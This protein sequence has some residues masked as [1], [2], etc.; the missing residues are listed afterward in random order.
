MQKWQ[1]PSTWEFQ[2]IGFGRW[3]E[4]QDSIPG[5]LIYDRWFFILVWVGILFPL[6]SPTWAQEYSELWGATGEKWSPTS[7]LPDFS[8]AGYH[9][10]EKPIPTI[11][12][13]A[14]VKS[15]GAKGDGHNTRIPSP[16]WMLLLL[17][18]ME[19]SWYLLVATKSARFWKS[20]KVALFFVV[21][22]RRKRCFGIGPKK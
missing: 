7:H 4:L 1:L 2:K 13:T 10:G 18:L 22:V 17:P 12:P 6:F 15:Y 19:R 20:T 3:H 14:N 21:L 5:R 9:S 11:P 8:F 16:F